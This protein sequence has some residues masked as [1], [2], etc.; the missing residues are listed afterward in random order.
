MKNNKTIVICSIVALI[1]LFLSVPIRPYKI[2][3]KNVNSVSVTK[4]NICKSTLDRKEI[5]KVVKYLNTITYRRSLIPMDE[6]NIKYIIITNENFMGI[7]IMRRFA[8]SGDTVEY[9]LI[10]NTRGFHRTYAV[11]RKDILEY[12]LDKLYSELSN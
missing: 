9:F 11:N 2:S 8:F 10:I 3:E 6:K 4:M 5:Q 7:K 1:I 12:N